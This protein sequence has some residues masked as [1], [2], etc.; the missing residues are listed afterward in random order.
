MWPV[1]SSRQVIAIVLDHVDLTPQCWICL[2]YPTFCK[3]MSVGRATEEYERQLDAMKQQ[4]AK[5]SWLKGIQI[6]YLKAP[7]VGSLDISSFFL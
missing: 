5:V 1:K 2:C 7:L 6:A 3:I 4:I